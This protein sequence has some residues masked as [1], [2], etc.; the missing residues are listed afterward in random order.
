VD[1][2]R[3]QI[4]TA[5][6]KS[7]RPQLIKLADKISNLRSILDTPPADWDHERKKEYFA[8]AKKVVDGLTAPDAMLKAEFEET[9]QEFER[10]SVASAASV[11]GDGD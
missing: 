10:V 9:L 11:A 8:W 5:P 3:L 2:K 7:R 6:K 4:E 1:R